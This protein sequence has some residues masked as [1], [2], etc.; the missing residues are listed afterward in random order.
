MTDL[1]TDLWAAFDA[2]YDVASVSVN[3]DSVKVAILDDDADAD[4]LRDVTEEAVGGDAVRGL[5]VAREAID[6][7]DQMGTVVSFRHRG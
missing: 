1:E 3:R 6:G 7:R 5:R 4:R 2:E